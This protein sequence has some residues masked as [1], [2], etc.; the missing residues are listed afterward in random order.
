MIASH[1]QK[2]FSILSYMD[3]QE[4]HI[5]KHSC[6]LKGLLLAEKWR[7]KNVKSFGRALFFYNY[8][9]YAQSAARQSPQPEHWAKS[10][11]AFKELLEEYLP[12]YI[13]VWGVR[14]YGGLPNW[15]GESSILQI[16]EKAKTDVWTYNIKGKR[17]PAIKVHHPSSPSGKRWIYWHEFYKEFLHL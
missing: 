8:I 9:Q 1:L 16:N 12:D 11:C 7:K 3:T 2:M 14:L 13:I 5:C 15:N 6:V 17:I 4:N 10:E